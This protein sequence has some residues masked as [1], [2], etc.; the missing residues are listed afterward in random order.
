MRA[1]AAPAAPAAATYATKKKT[2]IL[3]YNP[4]FADIF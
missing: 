4:D 3:A 1:A 2:H